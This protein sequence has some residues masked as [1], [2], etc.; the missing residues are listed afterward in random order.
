MVGKKIFFMVR[1]IA[2]VQSKRL[3]QTESFKA[4]PIIQS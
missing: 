1:T 2:Y 3:S 4:V